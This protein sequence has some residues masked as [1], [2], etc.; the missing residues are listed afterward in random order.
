MIKDVILNG[1]VDEDIKK[2]VLGMDDLDELNV[3]KLVSRIEGK[4]TARNALNKSHTL[5]ASISA[6][7]KSVDTSPLEEKKLRTEIKCGDCEVKIKA[8]VRGRQGKL[9]ERKY[10]RDCFLKSHKSKG[11]LKKKEKDKG[12]HEVGEIGMTKTAFFQKKN[13]QA[14]A[15][16]GQ[17]QLK[18]GLDFNSIDLNETSLL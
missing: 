8:Y 5:S 7:K 12:D 14:G 11:Q 2:E 16:L 6:F 10:C 9:L 1:L 13:E 4:E 17:A 15:E 3:E 18:L